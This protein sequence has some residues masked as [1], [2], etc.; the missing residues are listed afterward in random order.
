ML[1]DASLM[2]KVIK[3]KHR[4]ETSFETDLTTNARNGATRYLDTVWRA[5]KS[6][7]SHAARMRPRYHHQLPSLG[8]PPRSIRVKKT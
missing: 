2:I 8:A 4:A 5:L 6:E 7:R 3:N 1:I